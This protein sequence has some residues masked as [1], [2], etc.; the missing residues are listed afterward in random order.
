MDKSNAIIFK[1]DREIILQMKTTQLQD[2]PP[3]KPLVPHTPHSEYFIFLRHLYA[4][5]Q[6][7]KSVGTSRG[8][9]EH[10]RVQKANSLRNDN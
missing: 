5:P 8:G 6:V 10:M 1:I 4:G 2:Q 7:V 3:Q 9:G